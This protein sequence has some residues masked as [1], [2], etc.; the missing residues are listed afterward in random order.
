MAELLEMKSPDKA[1]KEN[2]NKAFHAYG[3]E[4]R[5]LL[6]SL[7]IIWNMRRPRVGTVA[8]AM[9]NIVDLGL[10]S[11]QGF[12]WCPKQEGES[13]YWLRHGR[14]WRGIAVSIGHGAEVTKPAR[15]RCK[16]KLYRPHIMDYC[17]ARGRRADSAKE[18]INK[19]LS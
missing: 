9:W 2:F 18:M 14:V 5:H 11:D 1:R 4:R 19:L 12:P 17:D 7:G 16:G 8:F 3:D 13:V 6:F 15:V 10:A